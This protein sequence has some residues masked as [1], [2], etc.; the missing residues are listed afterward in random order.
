MQ[1]EVYYFKKDIGMVTIQDPAGLI[2]WEVMNSYIC[3]DL[4]GYGIC[5]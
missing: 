2:S 4:D 5:I 3:A 1:A